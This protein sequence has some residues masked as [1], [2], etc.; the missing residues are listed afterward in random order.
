MNK[1][2]KEHNYICDAC[3][4]KDFTLENLTYCDEKIVVV[5]K[6]KEGVLISPVVETLG[7]KE[8]VGSWACITSPES[9]CELL[10]SVGV[11]GKMSKFFTYGEW[12]LGKENVYY[13]QDDEDVK[14]SVDEIILKDGKLGTSFQFKVVMKKEAKLSIVCMMLNIPNYEYP[15]DAKGLPSIV[16]YDVPRL[17][18]N[19][20]P[21]I[22]HE[23][24]SA[25]TSAMLLKFK[26]FDF[27][28]Q[29]KTYEHASTWG[30]FE[31][32]YVA[33]LV[34]DPGHHAPTFGNWVYNTAA[35]GAL[36][37]DSYVKRTY[38][39][40]EL[41]YH[42]ATV[43]PVG[44]SI[45]GDTG[46]Y[47]TGG[48]LLVVVGY[49]EVGNNKYVL[50]NDPNINGRFGRDKYGNDMFVYVEYPLDVFMNFFRGVIYVVE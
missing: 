19:M 44:A 2:F 39:W 43:G 50:C 9:T 28:E 12:G 8:I 7:F 23:M 20:V 22:G 29:A 17:N 15:V 24:C 45:K 46:I 21:V 5:D 18:Q 13:N 10:V 35:M 49:K 42:L 27:S 14:M 47:K 25:T 30:E 41:K 37:L 11:D 34:A 26:G 3:D 6:D 36:G 38:S 48:H 1:V 33:T 32:A 16:W 4:L 31:H 40:E